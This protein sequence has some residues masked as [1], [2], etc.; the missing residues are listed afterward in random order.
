[1]I[2]QTRL[3]QTW[4][5]KTTKHMTRQDKR[6]KKSKD[7]ESQATISK[8]A[9]QGKSTQHYT[10]ASKATSIWKFEGREQFP[11]SRFG[12]SE[13]MPKKYWQLTAGGL[14][15]VVP[16]VLKQPKAPNALPKLV[17]AAPVGRAALFSF[18]V[19]MVGHWELYHH[20]WAASHTWLFMVHGS[21]LIS[22]RRLECTAHI[23]N[24]HLS[25]TALPMRNISKNR[26]TSAQGPRSKKGLFRT[27]PGA[28]SALSHLAEGG[29]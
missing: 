18:T 15:W 19:S 25:T 4:L 21:W 10:K 13:E 23:A 1:M 27:W 29:D 14:H 5:D 11:Q 8:T 12:V 9:G 2:R 6:Y 20:V 7:K 3:D 28:R 17:V 22:E 26:H 24:K 16:N